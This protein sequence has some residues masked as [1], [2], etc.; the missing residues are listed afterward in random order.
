[1]FNISFGLRIEARNGSGVSPA[2]HYTKELEVDDYLDNVR[3]KTK[4]HLALHVFAPHFY[5]NI[6][7]LTVYFITCRKRIIIRIIHTYKYNIWVISIHL[8]R[9]ITNSWCKFWHRTREG[10]FNTFWSF[11]ENILLMI[12]INS[13]ISFLFFSS[14]AMQ[15]FGCKM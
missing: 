4:L 7:S 9:I 8:Q 14:I 3:L 6:K 15:T 12:K 2:S 1:M 5:Y 13:E 11:L 10:T